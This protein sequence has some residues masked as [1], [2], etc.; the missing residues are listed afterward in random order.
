M[1]IE[2]WR[3]VEASHFEVPRHPSLEVLTGE[4]LTYLGVPDS[5]F[6]EM[7]FL[8][9]GEW[10]GS[11]RYSPRYLSVM[12]EGLRSNLRK[13]IGEEGTD[14]VLQRSFSALVLGK[15]IDFD[16]KISFLTEPQVNAYLA[17][18]ISYLNGE[19]DLR[20]YVPGRGWIHTP[21][22]TA[23]LLA[24]LAK[25][26]GLGGSSLASL[27][28]AIGAKVTAR[29]DHVFLRLEDERLAYAAL[30]AIRRHLLSDSILDG[31]VARIS[32]PSP[33]ISWPELIEGTEAEVSAWHNA[34][35]FLRSLLLQLTYKSD[36]TPAAHAAAL[37]SIEVGLREM[38]LGFYRPG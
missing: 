12:G 21:A 2:F 7:S 25:N 34:R 6:R 33:G 19:R 13:G 4:L 8:V 9:L 18:A 29:V 15:I 32:R 22:H 14:S 28:E 3:A 5:E 31:W 24:A 27:L 16:A 38:D 11:G 1:D 17:D 36:E 23:D 10:I 35:D 37:R 20:G 30:C 26:P